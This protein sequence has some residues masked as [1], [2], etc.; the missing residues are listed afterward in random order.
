[1]TAVT[2]PFFS[3]LA[4]SSSDFWPTSPLLLAVL[5]PVLAIFLYGLYLWTI[6]TPQQR[7]HAVDVWIRGV[8][9][10]ALAASV[11]FIPP[12][13]GTAI[14]DI[15]TAAGGEAGNCLA[16][17]RVDFDPNLA[18]YVHGVEN[19]MKCAIEVYEQT[20][21]RI[22]D[23]YTNL[24]QTSTVSG[25]FAVTSSLSMGI[26][27]IALPFSG[28]ASGALIALTAAKVAAYVA[29]AFAALAGLGAVLIATERMQTLGAVI[30]A[31]AMAMPPVLAGL[32]DAIEPLAEKIPHAQGV[33]GAISNLN[34]FDWGKYVYGTGAV[35]EISAY[36]ALALSVMAAAVA[37]I[38][39]ALSRV[40]QHLSVE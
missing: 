9:A 29:I 10:G 33:L 2:T 38:S 15:Y 26:F 39:Y 11:F 13:I 36:T 8:V 20:Y 30:V 32:A 3:I 6:G 34:F 35:A 40:P 12:L 21:R 5:S 23:T 7:E 24:F 19:A 27:Q 4:S 14:I 31:G 17:L 37:A 28:A 18:R 25:I 16:P 1:M 22:A